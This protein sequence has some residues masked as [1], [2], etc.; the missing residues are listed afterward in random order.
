MHNPRTRRR[1]ATAA[2]IA[3]GVAALAIPATAQAKIVPGKSVA[4]VPLGATAKQVK[5]RLGAPERGST[6]LNYRYVRS[7]GFGLYLI[8]GKVFEIRVVKRPQ[9]TSKGIRIGSTLDAVRA[10]YPSANC[11]PAVVGRDAFDCSLR[12]RFAGRGTETVFS[13]VSGRVTSIAIHFA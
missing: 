13:T 7:R 10:A 6:A 9:A 8:A 5:D 4:G 11:T 3:L 12:G 2:A 1:P